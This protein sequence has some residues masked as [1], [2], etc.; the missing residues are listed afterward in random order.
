MKE[1][2]IAIVIDGAPKAYILPATFTV[3]FQSPD[4]YAS[5]WELGSFFRILRLFSYLN[6]LMLPA[7]YIAVVTF[8]YEVIPTELVYSFQ[9]SLSFVPFRPI[10]ELL[11][12]QFTFELLREASI[13][14]PS[15]IASTFGIVGAVVVGTAMVEAG[16]VSYGGLIVVALTA[17]SSFVQPNIEMSSTIRILGFPIMILAGTFGFLGIVL[18]VLIILIHL[19]RLTSF[20]VPYFSPFAPLKVHELKILLCES[21][22]G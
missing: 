19:S 3:F 16:F 21:L 12:M 5:R 17:V 22:Y 9:S 13:R 18:G 20:G 10:I 8:H 4:D 6:A 15:S 11:A 14:L 1:G 7:L 2:K